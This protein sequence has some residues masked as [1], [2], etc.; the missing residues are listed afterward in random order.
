MSI[1]LP[2]II[3]DFVRAKNEFQ[4]EAI[5]ACLTEDAIVE[6]EGQK[7]RGAAAIKDWLERIHAQYDDRLEVIGVWS[8]GSRY[9]VTAQVS[10]NFDGSPVPLDFDFVISAGKISALCITL[11]G[12]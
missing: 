6:D 8:E 4:V 7:L 5:L 3:A 11:H 1:K 9:I 12:E 10:G 2:S